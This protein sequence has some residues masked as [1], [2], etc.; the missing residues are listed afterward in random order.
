MTLRKLT[1]ILMAALTLGLT[2]GA[3]VAA[4]KAQVLKDGA[5]KMEALVSSSEGEALA[6][7]I[8]PMKEAGLAYQPSLMVPREGVMA[9]KNPEQLRM[10]Y[11]MYFIDANLALVFGKKAEF[12]EIEQ[13][14]RKDLLDKLKMTGKLK[15][16]RLSPD[17]LKKIADDPGNPANREVFVKIVFGNFRAW[18]AQAATDPE[19]MDLMADSVYG[20]AIQGIYVACKQAQAAGA[21]EKLVNLF[22]AQAKRLGKADQIVEAYAGDKELAALVEKDQRQKTL[23]PILALLKEKK[24]NLSETD[25]KQILALV[26]PERAEL[27]KVCQ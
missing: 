1:P 22:N 12:V 17:E 13:I 24:G 16:T 2:A 15:V 6:R 18:S 26:E 14:L 27:V 7:A 9:C 11:G 19:V 20:A 3:A 4:D 23:K 10:L 25:V 21:G 8:C 5:A